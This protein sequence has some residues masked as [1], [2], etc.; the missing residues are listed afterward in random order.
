MAQQINLFSPILLAPKRYFS[1]AAMGQALAVFALGMVALSAWSIHATQALRQNLAAA[2]AADLREK[3]SL[4]AELARQPA[5]PTDTA[6]LEQELAATVRQVAEREQV[7]AGL[8]QGGSGHSALL[9]LLAQSV[10]PSIWLSE[11]RI[12]QGRLELAGTTLQPEALRP[13]L[14]QL[15]AQPALEGQSLRAVKI[16]RSESLATEAWTFRVVSSQP[17]KEP[18]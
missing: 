1:A 16:E 13:W 7:L 4:T 17:R 12:V 9:R 3:R 11:I 6:A 10:P 14:A 8:P 18:S 5:L 15:A 2:T